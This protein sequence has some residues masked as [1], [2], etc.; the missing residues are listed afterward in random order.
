MTEPC[1]G[2][3]KCRVCARAAARKQDVRFDTSLPAG[4][5]IWIAVMCILI[6]IAVVLT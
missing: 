1:G 5:M 6:V 4:A 3:S 2:P